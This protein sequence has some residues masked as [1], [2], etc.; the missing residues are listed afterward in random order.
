MKS[1]AV[2]GE[3][4]LSTVSNQ[5]VGPDSVSCTWTGTVLANAAREEAHGASGGVDNNA[6]VD[7]DAFGLVMVLIL[8]VP[9]TVRSPAPTSDLMVPEVV[10]K[11]DVEDRCVLV[12]VDSGKGCKDRGNIVGVV[13]HER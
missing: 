2:A 7:S 12:G 4:L 9:G 8:W 10:N 1:P 5:T 6:D 11:E 3:L 13:P